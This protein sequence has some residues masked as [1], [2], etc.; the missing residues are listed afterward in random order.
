MAA[1]KTQTRSSSISHRQNIWEQRLRELEA[2]KKEH[3]HCNVRSTYA[4]N[5]SL[6][7]WVSNVRRQKQTGE[8]ATELA[9]CLDRLGF[10]W[11]LRHR[12]VYRRDWD[13]MVAT[14]TEFK[15][16]W[17]LLRTAATGRVSVAWGVAQGS[18]TPKKDW[19]FGS[20]TYPA[21]GQA[22]RHLGTARKTMGGYVRRPCSLSSETRRLQSACPLAG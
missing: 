14:L 18:A 4:A 22:R 3:G 2:F 17:T 20:W 6:A 7:K 5:P 19:A 15:P 1:R 10:T 11:V 21:T 16:A 12:T 8:I 9:R 13:T